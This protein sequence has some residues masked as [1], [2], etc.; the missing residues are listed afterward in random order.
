MIGGHGVCELSS[1]LLDRPTRQRLIHLSQKLVTGF[2]GEK[3]EASLLSVR[4][5]LSP[6]GTVAQQWHL[7]YRCE[8]DCRKGSNVKS[9]RPSVRVTV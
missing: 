8:G 1:S 7:D 5:L 9:A 2:E 3:S 6:P 4:I